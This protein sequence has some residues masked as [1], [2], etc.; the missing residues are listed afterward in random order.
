MVFGFN[1]EKAYLE[2]VLKKLIQTD[3]LRIR[4]QHIICINVAHKWGVW[5][6]QTGVVALGWEPVVFLG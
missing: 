1:I 5:D 6:G 2:T 4:I 3:N